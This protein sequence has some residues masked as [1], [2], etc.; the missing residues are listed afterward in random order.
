V[1]ALDFRVLTRDE[2]SHARTGELRLHHGLIETPVFMPVG[3]RA[4]VKS[5]TP[6]ELKACGAAIILGN[7]YHLYLR[8]GSS[9]IR[10]LGGLHRFMSWDRCT[11]TDSGGFQVFSLGHLRDIDEE[12]VTF[13]SHLDG[14]PH[15]FTPEKVVRIQ[16]E[17]GPDIAMV[18]DEC[19]PYP[20]TRDDARLSFERTSRWAERALA[21]HRRPDQALFG[22][23]QG[24][25]YANLRRESASQIVAFDFPGYAIG[26][27]S[28]GEPK[29][30][31]YE[32]MGVS[33]LAL[34]EDKPRY[35][36]GVGA[37]EDLFEA[38]TSGID[39]FDCVL[40]TRLGRNGALFTRD[41]RVNIRN[42]RFRS[43]E[44]PV[45]PWCDCYTCHTFTSAYLHHLFRA[46]EL[47]AYRLASLHNVRWTIKLVEEMRASIRQGVFLEF[48]DA[49]LRN[50]RVVNEVVRVEQRAKWTAA[51]RLR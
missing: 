5:L 22:I 28:V 20:A 19:T 31:F 32:M 25:M 13:R 37:P 48:R 23:A 26:G 47:L 24:G 40:Q 44:R 6:D 36:M 4:T 17:L 12:G 38:V 35:V 42:A 27:L 2:T 11:L 50:Y 8:P 21:A 1:P 49:F 3:T 30:M 46:E 14:S 45:D 39:M 51:K 16:E 15:M 43:D 33:A 29:A 9:L 18:L 7:T 34:P 41:G 10:D